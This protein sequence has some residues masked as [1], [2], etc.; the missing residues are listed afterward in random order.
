MLEVRYESAARRPE[1]R[2][3]PEARADPRTNM[4]MLTA[5]PP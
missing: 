4:V 2:G 1:V 5:R 3:G